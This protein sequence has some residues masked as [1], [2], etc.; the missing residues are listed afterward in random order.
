MILKHIITFN[1][2][3]ITVPI[4]DDKIDTEFENIKAQIVSQGGNADMLN[5]YTDIELE[6]NK[7][8]K[9]IN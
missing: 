1:G 6:E 7:D 4:D 5:I 9:F 8:W 3:P 2:R